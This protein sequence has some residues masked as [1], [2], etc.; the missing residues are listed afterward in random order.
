MKGE[1][2]F[3]SFPAQKKGFYKLPP[4]HVVRKFFKVIFKIQKIWKNSTTLSPN[5]FI[6]RKIEEKYPSVNLI[7][8][9]SPGKRWKI[10]YLLLLPK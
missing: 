8:T 10:T 3:S 9:P 6:F 7:A 5:T 1:K 4:P 2:K